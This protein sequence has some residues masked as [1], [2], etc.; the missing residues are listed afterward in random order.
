MKYFI[1]F[2]LL[3]NTYLF[4]QYN[5]VD[6]TK[7]YDNFIINNVHYSNNDSVKVN[8]IFLYLDKNPNLIKDVTFINSKNLHSNKIDVVVKI[9]FSESVKVYKLISKEENAEIDLKSIKC[10]KV[11]DFECPNNFQNNKF[12]T[13]RGKNTIYHFIAEFKGESYTGEF[14][15]F[16][17]ML[18]LEL[19]QKNNK[20]VDGY[21]L[22][23]E[24]AELPLGSDLYKIKAKN[25]ILVDSLP[26]SLL[27]FEHI[28]DDGSMLEDNGYIELIQ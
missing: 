3:I 13:I 17:D 6:F 2:C 11:I 1:F 26:I 20:I 9:N 25:I 18:I 16:H 4:G 12:K 10:L 22:T 24:W 14:K 5:L 7:D 19:N 28:I 8:E 23:K 15:N 21:H 27:R